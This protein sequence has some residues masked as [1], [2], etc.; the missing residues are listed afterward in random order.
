MDKNIMRKKAYS[1][2]CVELVDFS[3]TGSIAATCVYRGTNTDINT[4]G[5]VENGWTVYA[6]NSFCDIG[7]DKEFCYHTP[8]AD[9][10]IF[11]S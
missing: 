3:L 8:T 5:Y 4:C 6:Q 10:S 7:T 9:T 2:P 11:S 1:R